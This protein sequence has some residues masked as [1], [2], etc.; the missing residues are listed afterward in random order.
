[1]TPNTTPETELTQDLLD[2]VTKLSPENRDRL[3]TFIDE[4]DMPP[5]P[6]EGEIQRRLESVLNGTARLLTREEAN[7][8]VRQA[9]RAHGVEL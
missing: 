8:A 4:L 5:G 2:R 9:L 6:D 7:D 1:M 3:A